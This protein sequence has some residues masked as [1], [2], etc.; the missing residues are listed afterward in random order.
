MYNATMAIS[1]ED[2]TGNKW[3]LLRWIKVGPGVVGR[4][5]PV[6]VCL[7]LVLGLAIWKLNDSTL[8]AALS[9]LAVLFVIGYF[10]VAFWYANKYPD[11]STLDGGALVDYRRT[12]IAASDPKIIDLNAEVVPNPASHVEGRGQ[13]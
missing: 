13:K 10:A 3:D 5:V 4:T 2:S 6:A 9:G 12:Q 1:D 7:L 8:I 11:F